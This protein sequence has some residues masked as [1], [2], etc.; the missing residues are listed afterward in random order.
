MGVVGAVLAAIVLA[1]GT[2]WGLEHLGAKALVPAALRA[3]AWLVLGLLILD[4]SCAKPP[5]ATRPLA[6]CTTAIRPPP[7]SFATAF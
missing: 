6:L 1:G 5:A 3:V 4:L 2:Y 7:I